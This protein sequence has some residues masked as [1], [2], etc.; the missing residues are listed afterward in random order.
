MSADRMIT[1]MLRAED[2]QGAVGD[3][4]F[5]M[6]PGHKDY[7]ET[8]QH[9]GGLKPGQTKPYPAWPDE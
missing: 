6:S 5:F 3:A 4:A 7:E 8:I 9:V 2:G 1:V